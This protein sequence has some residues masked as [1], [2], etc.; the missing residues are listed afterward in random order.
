MV[1][2][3][4]KEN[5]AKLKPIDGIRSIN[6]YGYGDTI[7]PCIDV[8]RSPGS[9]SVAHSV[10]EHVPIKELNAFYESLKKHLII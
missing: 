2:A 5:L 6:L 3:T 10:D 7:V 9:L 8:A 1:S 4:F